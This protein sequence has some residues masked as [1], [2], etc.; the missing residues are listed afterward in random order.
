M[1][2]IGPRYEKLKTKLDI[3]CNRFNR[4]Q[5]K[6]EREIYLQH[7]EI[8]EDLAKN[9]FTIAKQKILKVGNGQAS[10]EAMELT[11]FYCKS[12]SSSMGTFKDSKKELNKNL[13]VLVSSLIW[14]TPFMKS[15]V[16]ELKWISK[17]L[18]AKCGKSHTSAAIENANGRVCPELIRRVKFEMGP[19]NLTLEYLKKLLRKYDL[20]N[21][22]KLAF[23]EYLKASKDE[24]RPNKKRTSP[25]SVVIKEL[26]KDNA[27]SAIK[28]GKPFTGWV[29]NLIRGKIPS[30]EFSQ[31]DLSLSKP[32]SKDSLSS[33]CTGNIYSTEE[34][35]LGY[36]NNGSYS[37]CPRKCSLPENS[38]YFG[39][40]IEEQPERNV[41]DLSGLNTLHINSI[42]SNQSFSPIANSSTESIIGS[43][44]PPE[45]SELPPAYEEINFGTFDSHNGRICEYNDDD[46]Q[47][48]YPPPLYMP[49]PA[50]SCP[51]DDL[52][53]EAKE[54]FSEEN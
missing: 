46:N 28:Y 38:N 27:R 42:C 19:E 47:F 23:E 50:P 12:L 17:E 35:Y 1:I 24:F 2:T 18:K 3:A 29:K 21:D 26:E 33:H 14:V 51:S 43:R 32:N 49:S 34:R 20:P 4:L 54:H 11:N 45:I 53:S 13:D 48:S 16:P 9:K 41:V 31:T 37:L 39:R 5:K 8:Q 25:T 15:Q 40:R 36:K 52:Y 44:E 30:H 6:S 7:K 10:L 22:K